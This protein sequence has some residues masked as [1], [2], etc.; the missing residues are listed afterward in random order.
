[1]VR[2]VDDRPGRGLVDVV[3]RVG[4]GGDWGWRGG[5]HAHLLRG[6]AEE[7]L[8]SVVSGC[9]RGAGFEW[10]DGWGRAEGW[11]EVEVP[12]ADELFRVE[13]ALVGGRVGILV[14]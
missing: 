8:L 13:E 10:V 2:Q 9:R 12:R 14:R 5:L 11:R 1:M 6:H 4:E 7:V 3:E